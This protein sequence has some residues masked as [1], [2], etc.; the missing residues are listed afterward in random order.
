MAGTDVRRDLGAAG[1]ESGRGWLPSGGPEVMAGLQSLKGLPGR[2]GG[3][4]PGSPWILNFFLM[5]KKE[6]I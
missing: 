2:V 5:K 1:R 4:C 3:G 6:R